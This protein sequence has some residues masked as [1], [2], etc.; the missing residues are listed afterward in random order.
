[1]SDHVEVLR[2]TRDDLSRLGL[3]KEVAAIDA[4]IAAF[5]AANGV[6]P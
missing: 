1:M 4:A 3:D 2:R 5:L 6:N